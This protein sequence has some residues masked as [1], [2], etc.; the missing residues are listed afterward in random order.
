VTTPWIAAF[1]GLSATVVILG[2]LVLGMLRRLAPLLERTEQV[3]SGAERRMALGGLPPGATVPEFVA[4]RSD[5]GAFTARELSESTTILLF[6]DSDC[7]ACEQLVAD[8]MH[9]RVPDLGVPLVVVSDDRAEA[10]TLARSTDVTVLID[11]DRSLAASFDTRATPQAF[12]LSYGTVRSSATPNTW[13]SMS[14]LLA[15]TTRGGDRETDTA[16]AAVAS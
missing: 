10:Q 16:A 7:K 12:V 13:E 3:L 2:L 4:E 5:G 11:Q 14:S 1:L 15:S 6:V 9:G 8:L